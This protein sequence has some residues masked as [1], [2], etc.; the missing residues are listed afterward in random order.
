MSAVRDGTHRAPCITVPPSASIA[1]PGSPGKVRCV[2]VNE[3]A[4]LVTIVKSVFE[5]KQTLIGA[6]HSLPR[7]GWGYATTTAITQGTALPGMSELWFTLD[8]DVRATYR[9]VIRR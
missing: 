6:P 4:G 3:S 5:I 7:D 8:A 1:I 9:G 2:V